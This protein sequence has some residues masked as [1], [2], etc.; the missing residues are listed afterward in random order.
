[1]NNVR[2]VSRELETAT[3]QVFFSLQLLSEMVPTVDPAAV[4]E[5]ERNGNFEQGRLRSASV[6]RPLPAQPGR[7]RP[8]VDPASQNYQNG[9]PEK[10]K[11]F[12]GEV[13]APPPMSAPMGEDVPEF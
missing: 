13:P 8:N 1:M 9:E 6:D 12:F 5:P 2:Q 10:V 4:K 11:K 3:S 7:A